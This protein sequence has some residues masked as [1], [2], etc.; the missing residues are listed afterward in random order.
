MSRKIL[1]LSYFFEPDLGAGSFRNTALA[2]KMASL[3]HDHDEIDLLT[4]MPNRYANINQAASPVEQRGVLRSRGLQ[5]HEA[6][7]VLYNR[8]DHFANTE[9]RCCNMS[10]IVP[11]IWCLRRVQ[12]YSRHT[13]PCKLPGPEIFRYM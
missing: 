13:S 11:M 7:T 3:M 6:L 12:S 9:D 4:T 8:S 2:E 1:Y 5:C 10:E